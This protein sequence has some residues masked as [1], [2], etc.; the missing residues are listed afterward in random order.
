[1]LDSW[2]QWGKRQWGE[3]LVKMLIFIIAN[4]ASM[5][6]MGQTVQAGAALV[7]R[8]SSLDWEGAA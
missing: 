1:M 2:L 7:F 8:D 6:E 4:D 3:K 5:S